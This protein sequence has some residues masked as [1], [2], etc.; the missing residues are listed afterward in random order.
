MQWPEMSS[1]KCIAPSWKFSMSRTFFSKQLA[2]KEEAR[3]YP[4][5]IENDSSMPTHIYMDGQLLRYIHRNAVSNA[6]KYGKLGGQVLTSLR[7]EKPTIVLRVIN[8]PGHEHET[9]VKMGKKASEAVF[10]E[11]RRLKVHQDQDD[12]LISSGDGAWIMS[13]CAQT[14]GGSCCID[15]EPTRTVFR[16]SCPVTLPPPPKNKNKFIHKN[17]CVPTGTI[18]IA[19]DDSTVQRR[20]MD[21]ILSHVGVETPNRIILGKEPNEIFQLGE[22]LIQILQEQQDSK[23]LMLVDENLDYTGVDVSN[24]LLISG[25]RV[26]FDVLQTLKPEDEAR[27][28]VL[29]RSANDSADDIASYASRAH[30]FFPKA[31]AQKDKVQQILAPLWNKRFGN[32]ND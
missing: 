8:E 32:N 14:L 26:M 5:Q 15:F 9:I 31:P 24:Q 23:I 27:V 10:A 1:I 19:I 16:F 2:Q 11:G 12:K 29:I 28:L 25:S 13:K 21:R 18:G 4:F 17:F 20:L 7:Y 3:R 6:C 30:G 22:T